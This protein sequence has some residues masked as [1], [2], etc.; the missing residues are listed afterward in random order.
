MKSKLYF[1][2]LLVHFFLVVEITNAQSDTVVWAWAKSLSATNGIYGHA[3]A[4]DPAGSGDVYLAG[5]FEGTTDFDPGP[6]TF[7]LKTGSPGD[8][9]NFVS[10][11]DR[12][13]NFKWAKAM[14]EEPGAGAGSVYSMA[15][16]PSGSGAIYIAGR[17]WGT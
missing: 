2:F 8:V 1:G 16:D 3:I 13:G 6:G 12:L 5:G 17:L 7:I 10:K 15:I 14:V 4:I 9:A 11:Y